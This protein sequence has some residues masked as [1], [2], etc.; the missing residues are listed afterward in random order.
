[1]LVRPQIIGFALPFALL[2]ASLT[3]AQF[4]PGPHDYLLTSSDL[5]PN[6]TT[7][8]C[9]SI[10]PGNPTELTQGIMLTHHVDHNITVPV[11]GCINLYIGCSEPEKWHDSTIRICNLN[12]QPGHTLTIPETLYHDAIV[13]D[14]ERIKFQCRPRSYPQSPSDGISGQVFHANKT[15][16]VEFGSVGA[17]CPDGSAAGESDEDG[18]MRNVHDA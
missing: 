11:D 9:G 12:Q 10:P 3:A 2:L 17:G 18:G 8:K 14:L 1:M 13:A 15:L 6:S 5:L 7:L 4:H 16:A